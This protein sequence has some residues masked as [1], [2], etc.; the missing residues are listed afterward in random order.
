MADRKGSEFEELSWARISGIDNYPSESKR[1]FEI[2]SEL[3][4]W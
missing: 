4:S 1:M 3:T 2:V